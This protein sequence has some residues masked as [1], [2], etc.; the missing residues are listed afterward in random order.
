M[1]MIVSSILSNMA[2]ENG[3]VAFRTSCLL[4]FAT[5]FGIL[6]TGLGFEVLEP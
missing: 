3:L 6:Y 5:L 1:M 2:R 4:I